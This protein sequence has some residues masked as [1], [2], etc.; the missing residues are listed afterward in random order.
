[1]L[2]SNLLLGVALGYVFVLF[3]VAFLSDRRADTGRARWLHSPLVYTLAISIYCTSWTFY[4][5]VGNAAR[6]G[7][8]FMTIY[9]GP[10]LV[11]VGWYWLLRKLVRIGRVHRITSIAD[12]VSSRYGK[13]S[14]LAVVVTLLALTATTPY[15]ALQLQSITASFEAISG[16]T[17]ETRTAFWVACGLAAFT[18]L[19]GTRTINAN[20]RHH[21]V[22]AAIAL[23]AVVKLAAL[24][25]VGIFAVWGVAGGIG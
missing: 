24:L 5:A 14:T 22:V 6:S 16:T 12:L 18:I 15:I 13:S 21:G 25:A 4:G 3:V 19:F 17:H 10:T 23:E 11:F 1:M 7:L 20:E 2:S 8:E 9:L